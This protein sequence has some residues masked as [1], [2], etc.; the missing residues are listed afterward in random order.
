MTLTQ[1]KSVV[2]H[3]AIR[4][5]PDEVAAVGAAAVDFVR[6]VQAEEGCVAY[7]LSWDVADPA[8]LRLLEH[9]R[10]EAAYDVHRRQPH[11]RAWAAF[12]S[13]A[14]ESQLRATKYHATPRP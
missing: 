9:W 11:V 12:V 3:G 14:Q 6:A 2:V 10:D 7:E 8:C 5:R 4:L 13:A 1:E